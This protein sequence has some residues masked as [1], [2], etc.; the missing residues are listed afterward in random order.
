MSETLTIPHRSKMGMCPVNGIRDLIQ[1]RAGRDWS[2]E[3]LWGLGQGGGF[4]YLRINL[5]DP[6]RQMYTGNATPRQH[7]YL[8]ELLCVPFTELENRAFKTAWAK[9]LE[10]LDRGAPPILGPLD[11]YY[12]PY[13]RG[14]YHQR[15]IPIHFVLLVG[16]TGDR[17]LILDTG[18]DEIQEIPLDELRLAWDVNVPG[19]GKRNRLAVFETPPVLPPEIEM[20]R[21]S[22]ADQSQLMLRPPVSILGIPAMRKL[23]GDLPGWPAELGQETAARCL[24][25]VRE[26]L[27]SPPDPDGDHLTAGRD[28]YITFLQ[29]AGEMTGL[30]FAEPIAYLR[31]SMGA[32]PGIAAAIRQ[33]DLAAA[34]DGFTRMADAET[35]AFRGLSQ[36]V[37][38]PIS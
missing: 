25:Q 5:A 23:A 8:A 13:Y 35:K 2:N 33:N 15:H 7:R 11:M 12:L 20:I 18:E 29:E 10:A 3:F 36:V 31:E 17:A 9:A 27:N 34:S 16:F 14:I 38:A 28:R 4:S 19:I 21:K 1:W 32:V 26:Y 30:D 24:R 37:G 6:P 22:I